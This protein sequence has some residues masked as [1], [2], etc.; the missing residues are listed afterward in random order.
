M[1]LPQIFDEIHA[2][3]MNEELIVVGQA[4][5]QIE[6]GITTRFLRV[7][8]WRQQYAVGDSA[9]ENFAW[10]GDA[11]GASGSPR[12]WRPKNTTHVAHQQRRQRRAPNFI[13][14]AGPRQGSAALPASP[15][16]APR[17][18]SRSQQTRWH[19]KPATMAR[20][21][22]APTANFADANKY[23]CPTSALFR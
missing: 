17:P 5:E 15:D 9:H 20:K 16:R 11:F 1:L 13:H 21:K 22:H 3:R 2:A 18:D 6:D 8:A 4:V 7:V 23:L 19:S 12:R 14:T 10:Q